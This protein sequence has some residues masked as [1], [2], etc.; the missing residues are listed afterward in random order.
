MTR[1]ILLFPIRAL[2]GWVKIK[3]RTSKLCCFWNSSCTQLPE[4][5]FPPKQTPASGVSES[6]S[7]GASSSQTY[8]QGPSSRNTCQSCRV[9]E[10]HH[11]KRLFPNG[12]SRNLPTLPAFLPHEAG[13]LSFR[14]MRCFLQGCGTCFLPGLLGCLL[15]F[16]WHQQLCKSSRTSLHCDKCVGYYDCRAQALPTGRKNAST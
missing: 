8:H 3:P 13:V 5:P 6:D 12:L 9:E 11:R 14:L 1:E 2:S 15:L 7:S 16:A 10:P 4:Q